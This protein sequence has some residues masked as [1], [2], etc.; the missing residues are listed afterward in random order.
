MGDISINRF[1]WLK[2][3]LQAEGLSP[4]AKNVASALAVQFARDTTG[5]LNPSQNTL[6]DYLKVHKDTV[7]RVMRELRNAGWVLVL[8]VGGRSKAPQ[9]NLVS[10]GKIVPFRSSERGGKL[11]PRIIRINN[12]MNK[13]GAREVKSHRRACK[14]WFTEAATTKLR[15]M[16]GS[17]I[18]A[19]PLCLR[20]ANASA[21]PRARAGICHGDC[22]QPRVMKPA[23]ELL[24]KGFGGR[25]IA[26]TTKPD[27]RCDM[28][29]N[30]IEVTKRP[31]DQISELVQRIRRLCP[32]HRDPHRFH[33]EKS[34]I[35]FELTKLARRV[36]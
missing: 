11:P 26:A 19:T 7:K 3:V 33:E 22:H 31:S 25:S 20:L 16:N 2:A 34:E 1:E 32:D 24:R 28:L 15:G 5:Q 4:T 18:T 9:V 27:R 6:A 10:P 17:Q 36:A 14:P 21:M 13:G 12:L 23:F 29:R 35:A 8:G 30:K